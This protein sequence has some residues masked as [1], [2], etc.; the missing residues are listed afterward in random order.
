MPNC[1]RASNGTVFSA[2]FFPYQ[3]C[4]IKEGSPSL[5]G[6]FFLDFI[7]KLRLLYRIVRR[8]PLLQSISWLRTRFS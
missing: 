2:P 5:A 6:G 1:V 3:D 8:P 4:P 7:G